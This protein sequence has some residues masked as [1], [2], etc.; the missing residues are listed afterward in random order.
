[1]GFSS[2]G[3]GCGSTFHFE[4]PLYPPLTYETTIK[5]PNCDIVSSLTCK[6]RIQT[7][8][9][10]DCDEIALAPMEEGSLQSIRHGGDD[11]QCSDHSSVMRSTSHVNSSINF[12]HVFHQML[13]QRN[14]QGAIFCF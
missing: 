6:S 13:R 5:Y 9:R 1:M 3:L 2:A 8:F 4:L 10:E 11:L 14:Y 7:Q 12:D